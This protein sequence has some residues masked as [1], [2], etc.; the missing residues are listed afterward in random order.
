MALRS[1]PVVISFI[2]PL[3]DL[4]ENFQLCRSQFR[5]PSLSMQ[6]RL[7]PNDE[8]AD[9]RVGRITADRP[10]VLGAHEAP[11]AKHFGEGNQ[12]ST[13][14]HWTKTRALRRARNRAKQNNG[15][16]CRGRWHI[17][18]MLGVTTA[19]SEAT[20]RARRE[21]MV[22]Q[23]R[24]GARRLRFISYN[25]GGLDPTAFD[26]FKAWLTEQKITDVMIVQELH[27]GCGR[28]DTQWTM[29]NGWKAFISADPGN[30]WAGVGIFLAPWIAQHATTSA[31]TWSPGRILHVRSESDRLTLDVIGFYQQVR[32]AKKGQVNENQRQQHWVK[33]GKLLHGLPRRNLLLVGM[34]ANS[35]CESLP[36]L[37]GRVSLRI[38]RR[39][40][41]SQRCWIW[42]HGD[43][44]P[45][46]DRLGSIPH[47]AGWAVQRH[48]KVLTPKL[49][50]P[51]LREAFRRQ[52]ARLWNEL[53]PKIK[54]IVD[55]QTE[56]AYERHDDFA[57]ATCTEVLCIDEA[58]VFQAIGS[59][60]NNK[61]VPVSSLPAE[62]WKLCQPEFASLL[63]KVLHQGVREEHRYPKEISNCRTALGCVGGAT[64]GL[65]L[66]RAF[67]KLPRWALQASLEHASVEPAICRAVIDT[68][69]QC[70]YSIRHGQYEGCIDMRRGIRQGCSLSPSLY[71]IFTIWF[72]DRLSDIT[73]PEWANACVTLFADD[74]HLAWLISSVDD[75]E[76]VCSTAKRWIQAHQQQTA[77]GPVI[78][79]GLPH[80]PLH[81]AFFSEQLAQATQC[82]VEAESPELLPCPEREGVPCDVC[83]QYF[84]DRIRHRLQNY[85]VLCGQWIVMRG[86]GIKQ[87][88]RL[89]HKEAHAEHAAEVPRMAMNEDA[90][91]SAARTELKWVMGKEGLQGI[92]TEGQAATQAMEDSADKEKDQPKSSWERGGKWPRV[93]NK[94]KGPSHGGWGS[95]WRGNKRQWEKDDEEA[96][97]VTLDKATQAVLQSL[98]QLSLSHEAEL[99]RLRSDCGFM[100]FLD[101]PTTNPE[102]GILPGVKKVAQEW[103][104]QYAAGNVKSPLRTL[105]M[106]E[107]IRE[108]Q[109]RLTAF[110]A[111]ENRCTK[112]MTIGWMAEGH[113]AMDPEGVLLNFRCTKDLDQEF[114]PDL[115]VVPFM[116]TIGL[117]VQEAHAVHRAFQLLSGNAVRKLIGA[118]V[119]PERLARQPVAKQLEENY[120]ATPYCPWSRRAA[121]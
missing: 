101:T 18:A 112:A 56:E 69:E 68:H 3:S 76:F 11:R 20:V 34:D 40:L 39:A 82:G 96:E 61:A 67:D 62:I 72:F 38:N 16:M 4:T 85:C 100:L 14:P 83:G 8:M 1:A 5:Q 113:Q 7:R 97:G 31:C 15:T 92:P 45:S 119:R 2:L 84:V 91:A 12:T 116:L 58:E 49:S 6:A 35:V 95:G 23:S 81:V 30:R 106:M 115:E 108:L 25:I 44:A 36:G 77:E 54:A 75:L 80:A 121:R 89:M 33:F 41:P 17:P 105:L 27:W 114:Q 24:N 110:L 55:S 50:I 42:C 103:A 117:R 19:D 70:S 74:S 65:D 109:G 71:T 98:V 99:G 48:T 118:R 111:D 47:I 79:V 66:S 93:E 53:Q 52:D 29:D 28:E 63:H 78:N 37:V 102:A 60:K 22:P 104:T 120:L 94:G 13:T 10:V 57:A 9:L 87:H 51:S 64:I 43:S 59:L 21:K 73:S 90:L 32:Q 107:V 88:V 86:P 46:I 26:V